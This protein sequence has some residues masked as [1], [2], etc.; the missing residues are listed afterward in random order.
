MKTLKTTLVLVLALAA[1][2][3]FANSA[4]AQDDAQ[5]STIPPIPM[6]TPQN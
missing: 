2:T 5:S 3:A 4:V 6:H 1:G